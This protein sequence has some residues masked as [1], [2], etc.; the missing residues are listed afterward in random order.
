VAERL[1]A[2]AE[3]YRRGELGASQGGPGIIIAERRPLAMVQV[4]ALS[5][6]AATVCAGIAAALGVIPAATPNHAA[7]KDGVT[8][9]WV[10]P[11]RW[12]VV[13]PERPG[14]ELIARLSEALTSTPAVL[15]DLSHGRTVFRITGRSS[16]DLL[17]K[18]CGIDFHP[19]AFPAGSC[20]QS[21]FGHVGTLLHAVDEAPSFDLYLARS[22][23]LTVWEWITESAAEYGCRIE[24]AIF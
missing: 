18:G 3:A 15:V 24:N 7:Q 22:F 17:A 13:E 8:V 10:G 1:S 14:R 12:L 16:R 23:A 11:D 5:G 20:A 21:L 6:A 4:T 19:R 2:I 9:I